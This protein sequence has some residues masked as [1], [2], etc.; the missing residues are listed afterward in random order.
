MKW[1]EF[2][3]DFNKPHT[4][5]I[6]YIINETPTVRTFVFSDTIMSKSLPGQFAMVWIP[7]IN[8]LPMS[9]MVSNE[10]NKAAFTVRKRGINSTALYNLKPG[11]NIGVRG[12]YG[13]NFNIKNGNILLV[14]GGTGLVPLMRLL[15]FVTPSNNVK[16]IIGA[17]TQNEVF[18]ENLAKILLKNNV[19]DI[20]ITTIDGSYGRKGLVTDVV[21]E[22][23]NTTKF[24]GIY[25]C[26][27]ELMMFHT[28]KLAVSKKVFIQASVERIMKCGIGICGSCSM[29]ENLICK[30][31]TVFNGN[32]LLENNEFGFSYR[33]KSGSIIKYTSKV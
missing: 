13:N 8:E 19:H 16:L 11:Q 3:R 21:S 33:D 6:E 5:K 22:L 20:I 12:P 14:G 23:L 2:L 29:N 32:Y 25:T 10:K 17:S 30:D 1:L 9:I 7:G 24:N 18:F 28:I 31:G 4:C 15:K 27:P 26:G